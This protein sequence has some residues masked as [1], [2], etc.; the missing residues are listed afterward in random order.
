[1]DAGN[2][3]QAQA[4]SNKMKGFITAPPETI[5]INQKMIPGFEVR[6]IVNVIMSTNETRP[7]VASQDSRRFY[8]VWSDL[9]IQG[10]DNQ[11]LSH[12]KKY[13]ND[14]WTW[15]RDNKGWRY[16]IDFL[17]KRDVSQFNPRTTPTA[18]DDLI[19]IREASMDPV[20]MLFRECVLNH[21]SLFK[22]DLL[23]I[24]DIYSVMASVNSFQMGVTI[25]KIPSENVLARV[26]KQSNFAKMFRVSKNNKTFKLY[27]IRNLARYNVMTKVNIRKQYTEQITI[28]KSTC[29]LKQVNE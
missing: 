5:W 24:R 26:I 25:K 14:L 16:C 18:T 19:D 8:V 17:M 7:F 6:N 9:N 20:L 27:C 23:T 21:I 2:Y 11:V 12:Y 10:E 3:L 13:Y 22:S 29:N 4:I 15:L 1:M 28:A